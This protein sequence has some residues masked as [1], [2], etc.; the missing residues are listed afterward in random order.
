[1]KNTASASTTTRR[2][3]TQNIIIPGYWNFSIFCT[4]NT[5]SDHPVQLSEAD[6]Y[7]HSKIFEFFGLPASADWT[8]IPG[9][10]ASRSNVKSFK[11]IS[12]V[13]CSIT[14]GSTVYHFWFPSDEELAKIAA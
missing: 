7:A 12:M 5:S 6:T 4:V 9:Y 14:A 8:D 11:G 2:R 1:M 13:H 3:S 10:T